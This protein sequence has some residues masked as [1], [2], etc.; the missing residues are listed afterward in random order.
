MLDLGKTET[1]MRSGVTP[2]I[3]GVTPQKFRR[4]P[5]LSRLDSENEPISHTFSLSGVRART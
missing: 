2:G 1:E 5:R 4:Y 3:S